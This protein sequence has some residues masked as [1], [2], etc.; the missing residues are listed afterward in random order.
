MRTLWD[1]ITNCVHRK[2]GLWQNRPS[3]FPVSTNTVTTG[4]YGN[5]GPGPQAASRAK[6]ACVVR[7]GMPHFFPR[8]HA[9][10]GSLVPM[11]DE[12]T[13]TGRGFVRVVASS[14]TYVAEH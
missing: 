2:D 4:A 9:W 12:K 8:A 3:T 11:D 6:D 7:N 13:G 14:G 10:F 5:A 1:A